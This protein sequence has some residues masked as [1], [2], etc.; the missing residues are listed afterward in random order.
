MQCRTGKIRE[1]V[2]CGT[3]LLFE[4]KTKEGPIAKTDEHIPNLTVA[5]LGEK[6]ETGTAAMPSAAGEMILMLAQSCMGHQHTGVD[7]GPYFQG[8][9]LGRA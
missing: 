9:G 7:V 2:L 3:Y 4:G 1:L 6:L 8:D 5:T